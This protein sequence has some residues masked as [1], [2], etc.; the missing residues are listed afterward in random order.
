MKNTRLHT[1]LT[2]LGASTVFE[3]EDAVNEVEMTSRPAE[4]QLKSRGGL[5]TIERSR[6]LHREGV[7][8]GDDQE[9][10]AEEGA[11]ERK[12]VIACMPQQRSSKVE[13]SCSIVIFKN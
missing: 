3:E 4:K 9:D 6:R 2:A 5:L 8:E 1:C 12:K 7:V 10:L 13:V 11:E